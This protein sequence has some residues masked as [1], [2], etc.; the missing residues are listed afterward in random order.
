MKPQ[1][2]PYN[3]KKIE[4]NSSISGSITV[5]RRNLTDIFEHQREDATL[6]NLLSRFNLSD[7]KQMRYEG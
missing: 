1:I 5:L 7:L 3:E 6:M 2:H 4:V